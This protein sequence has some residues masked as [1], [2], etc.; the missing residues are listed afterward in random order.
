VQGWS[1]CGA[2]YEGEKALS[3]LTKAEVDGT[4]GHMPGA[5]PEMG[6]IL[7]VAA[8]VEAPGWSRVAWLVQVEHSLAGLYKLF[9]VKMAKQQVYRAA[10]YAGATKEGEWNTYHHS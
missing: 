6:D 1:S 7:A 3:R 10:M 4:A 8:G 5:V 9:V 2:R